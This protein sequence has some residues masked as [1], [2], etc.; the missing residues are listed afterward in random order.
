[1]LAVVRWWLDD[2][3][4]FRQDE[5]L[6][7]RLLNFLDDVALTYKLTG[8]ELKGMAS[9]VHNARLHAWDI[10]DP[11]KMM[12]FLK[13]APKPLMGT[14]LNETAKKGNRIVMKDSFDKRAFLQHVDP[15]ELA[16]QMALLHFSLTKDIYLKEFIGLAW[17]KKGKD[18]NAPHILAVIENFNQ[19]MEKGSL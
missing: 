19:V 7:H 11:E 4:D 1:M 3:E 15:K 12:H 18:G 10:R 17:M 14:L 6:R 9:D 5:P 8:G 13:H 16:R 2:G